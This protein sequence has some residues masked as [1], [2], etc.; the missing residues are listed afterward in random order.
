MPVSVLYECQNCHERVIGESD[1]LDLR[2]PKC[3]EGFAWLAALQTVKVAIPVKGYGGRRQRKRPKSRRSA[4]PG[5][6]TKEQA[7]GNPE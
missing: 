4:S 1:A 2:C 7:S 6:D 5:P 3:N